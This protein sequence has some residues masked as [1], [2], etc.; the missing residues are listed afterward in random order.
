MQLCLV[1]LSKDEL[2]LQCPSETLRPSWEALPNFPVTFCQKMRTTTFIWYS[3][4]K[5]MPPSPC[6][7]NLFW[8]SSSCHSGNL[9]WFFVSYEPHISAE[10]SW[11][12]ENLLALLSSLDVRGKPL[13]QASHWAESSSLGQ[14]TSFRTQSVP[15]SLL[16]ED[17]TLQVRYV[18]KKSLLENF[19][20]KMKRM[21]D[22]NV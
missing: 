14:R 6:T 17:L 11:W 9:R 21:Q 8:W 15:N 7:G 16:I 3:G 18:Q 13:N 4:L 12:R 20:E 10:L 19:Q 5:E 22:H 2:L 1:L